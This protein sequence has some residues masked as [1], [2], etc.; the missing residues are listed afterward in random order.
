MHSIT[1]KITESV[2][3]RNRDKQITQ[4]TDTKNPVRFRYR[5]DRSKGSWFVVLN[6]GGKSIWRK[7]GNYPAIQPKSLF[8]N[9][10][11]IMIAFGIDK[12]SS[13]V[14]VGTLETVND[15]VKW[16]RDRAIKN[17]ELSKQRKATIKCCTKHLVSNIGDL[18]IESLSPDVIDDELIQPLVV[19]GFSKAYTRQIYD[20]LRLGF[21]KAHE[22][23]KITFNPI[24]G[25]SFS[26]FISGPIKPKPGK[27]HK[28][29]LPVLFDQLK[30]SEAEKQTL[31]VLMLLH[32][33]R[34]GETKLIRWDHIDWGDR[35]LILPAENT[36]T[37]E[38]HHI[39]LTDTAVAILKRYRAAQ[40]YEGYKGVY[41]FPNGR[42]RNIS[43]SKASEYIRDISGQEWSAHDLRKLARSIWADLDID[44]FVSERLLNH[45]M[46]NLDQTYIHTHT[47]NRKRMALDKYHAWLRKVGL[48][49]ILQDI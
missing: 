1:A 43:D 11:E 41:L 32:G 38:L 40:E 29:L 5:S 25:I 48:G 23:K 31:A 33:T 45:K 26:S 28:H 22:V 15:V 21:K 46:K 9:L 30:M 16:Y 2:I 34:I 36:K 19:E 12:N 47:E 39:P 17:R 8:K 27:L 49:K 13:K 7:V 6:S 10:P 24:A 20:L 4:I 18:D 37:F 44:Y 35:V 3:E 42:G 14:A